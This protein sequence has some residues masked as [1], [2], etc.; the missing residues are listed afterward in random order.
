MAKTPNFPIKER[1]K[2]SKDSE[3]SENIV[4]RKDIVENRIM[5]SWRGRHTFVK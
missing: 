1:N 4:A 5:Y 2:Y 3:N